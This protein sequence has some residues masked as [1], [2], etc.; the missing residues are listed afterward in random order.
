MNVYG[1]LKALHV[2]GVVVFLGNMIVTAVWKGRADRQDDL[3]VL[4]YAQRLVT[5]TDLVFTST[6]AMLVA[7][8][9]ILLAF[10]LDAWDQ[11]WIMEGLGV[12]VLSGVIWAVVLIPTQN[13][14]RALLSGLGE[15][16]DIPAEY[17]RLAKRWMIWGVVAIVL[18]L[19][20]LITMIIKPN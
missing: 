4:Q 13:K 12:F 19:H 14:Q 6:G 9:G 10:R 1:L 8:T 17:S 3:L 11:R 7:V 16:E 5:F 20:A 15:G 18:P 2:F